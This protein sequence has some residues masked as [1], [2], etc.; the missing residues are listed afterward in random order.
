MIENTP[1]YLPENNEPPEFDNYSDA[2]K[3]LDEY[4]QELF[5]DGFYPTPIVNG[6][7]EYEDRGRVHDLGRVVEIVKL[8]E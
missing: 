6:F 4:W 1:G 3:H 8:E 2:M 5:R 7:F